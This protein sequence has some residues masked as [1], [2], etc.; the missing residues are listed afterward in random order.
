VD[1]VS[2]AVVNL[3]NFSED[4]MQ[5]DAELDALRVQIGSLESRLAAALPPGALAEAE[6]SVFSQFGE[7]GIIQHLLRHVRIENDAFVEFGVEDYKESN[8]RFLL[9]HDNWR[10][11]VMDGG[12]SHI[13][14][15][16]TSGLDWKHEIHAVSAFIDR[17]NV[18]S[19]IEGAGF[20]GDIGL[21]SVDVDGN[22]YW[23]VEAVDVISPRVLVV[24]YNSVFGPS[25]PITI[26]YRP[27][28]RRAHAHWSH[29]Y[30][31]A[32]IAALAVIAGRKG[33]ALVGGNSTGTNAFFVRR[34]VLGELPEATPEEA[35]VAS[36][37]R[38][39]RDEQ[40]NLTLVTTHTDRVRLIASLPVVDVLRDTRTTV[41]EALAG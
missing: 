22:D 16:R 9:V 3:A 8:T 4:K 21:L 7:D 40:G 5:L 1:V 18:N 11:L 28:F 23:L 35:W 25:A 37:C 31:G 27:D 17:D 38:D 32:S 19:L 29:L 39:S 13:E 2:R 14:F 34:D 24:E 6:F 33:Y 30:W 41:A 26:P 15:L 12:S 20:I 10:G 36:R